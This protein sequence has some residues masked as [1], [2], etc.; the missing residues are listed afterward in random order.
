MRDGVR[1]PPQAASDRQ[2]A[3][4]L[5][6]RVALVTGVGPGLG[7][8]IAVQLARHGADVVLVARSERVMPAVAAEIESLGRRAWQVCADVTSASDCAALAERVAAIGPLDILVN[9]AFHA[10]DMG[11]FETADLARWRRPVD[12][13]YFGTLQVTQALLPALKAAGDA[14]GDARI[15]M[16]NT[17]SIHDLEAGHGSYAGSK[18]LLRLAG[19]RGRK[20]N[21]V[22][23]RLRGSGIRDVPGIPAALLRDRRSGRV[24]RV[25]ARRVRHRD[26]TSGERRAL[27]SAVCVAPAM[28]LRAIT[29]P[30][31][32]VRGTRVW[33]RTSRW[34]S[35]SSCG[36]WSAGTGAT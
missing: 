9:S 33:G 34:A 26:G 30:F 27:A 31:A 15:V 23:R 11:R 13:N 20:G 8:D 36:R 28:H 6:G 32:E 3:P 4:M 24:L 29:L 2:D 10:G 25:T 18:A 5:E 14:R 7:R 21:D 12:V 17:M 22:G 16:I 1:L 35:R 19:N